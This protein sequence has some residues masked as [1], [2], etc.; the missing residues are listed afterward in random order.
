MVYID[1][2]TALKITKNLIFCLIIHYITTKWY[3]KVY[4]FAE[5]FMLIPMVYK[6]NRFVIYMKQ[7]YH[8]R[9]FFIK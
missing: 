2:T 5:N 9:V 6:L 8:Y 1:T 7:F 3:I 4:L